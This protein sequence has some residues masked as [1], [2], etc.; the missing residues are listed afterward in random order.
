MSEEITT[1]EQNVILK[2]RSNVVITGISSVE[3]FDENSIRVAVKEGSVLTLEGNDISIKDVN[4]EKCSLEAQGEFTSFY[5][6]DGE[7][8]KVGFFSGLFG[9]K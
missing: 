3:S 9:R 1:R 4:L 2:N 6:D 7:R 5:Y 8:T